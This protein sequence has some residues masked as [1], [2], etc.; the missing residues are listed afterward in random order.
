[1][2]FDMEK[3]M[4]V[5]KKYWKLIVSAVS[6]ITV[7]VLVILYIDDVSIRYRYLYGDDTL[8]KDKLKREFYWLTPDFV[9]PDYVAE[10]GDRAFAG[11]H[12]MKSIVIPSSVKKFGSGCFVHCA[13]KLIVKCNIPD[14]FGNAVFESSDFTE[15]EICEG[16]KIV[17]QKAFLDSQCLEKVVMGNSVE[18]IGSRTF[19]DCSN[20]KSITIGRGVEYIGGEAFYKSKALREV[21]IS[22]LAAWCGIEFTNKNSSPLFYK[23]QLYLNGEPVTDVVIP[24]SVEW[25][26]NYAF[27]GCKHIT[28][29]VTSGYTECVG[30]EAFAECV[31]LASL[32]LSEGLSV[33]GSGA[34]NGCTSLT[35]LNLP[36]SVRVVGSEAF[37]GC[38]KLAEIN[39]SSSLHTIG[40]WAFSDCWQ[41]KT[42]TLPKNL[43]AIE[44]EAFSR[45]VNLESI[46]C[47]SPNPMII[48]G[49]VF[50][51]NAEGRKIYVPHSAVRDY[52]NH[53][54]WRSYTSDIV[55]YKAI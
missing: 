53:Y 12:D 46:Y 15:V 4:G 7:A 44:R 38:H 2:N 36:N 50:Y 41:L 55:G 8:L 10:I 45:C 1:M 13:G 40:S 19:Q 22:D 31:N 51:R 35:S 37:K 24:E 39:F 21:H 26:R 14:E 54:F 16:V 28:G 3:L 34:F 29:V 42:I 47:K 30:N 5:L 20:L 48:D 32:T 17:G 6:V 9:I 27:Y 23:A 52:K 11:C 43:Q 18:Y 25:V 33:I 49:D